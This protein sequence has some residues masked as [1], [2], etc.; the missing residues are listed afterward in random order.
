MKK[1]KILIFSVLLFSYFVPLLYGQE[2]T[3]DIRIEEPVIRGDINTPWTT[4]QIKTGLG[5]TAPYAT[6][7]VRGTK[8][9]YTP[10]VASTQLASGNIELARSSYPYIDFNGWSLNRDYDARIILRNDNYLQI[11]GGS[12]NVGYYH[13]IGSCKFAVNGKSYFSNYVGIGTNNP[14]L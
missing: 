13:S 2:D 9:D 5:T 8:Y 6:F 12:L 11:E 1:S 14:A 7:E 4:T 3:L 10:N